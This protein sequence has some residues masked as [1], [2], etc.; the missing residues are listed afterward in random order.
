MLYMIEFYLAKLKDKMYS[1]SNYLLR[2]NNYN[3]SQ[4]SDLII[5]ILAYV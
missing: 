1:R 5:K 3:Y 2:D 4:N